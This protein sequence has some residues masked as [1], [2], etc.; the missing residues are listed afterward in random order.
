MV[1]GAGRGESVL[2]PTLFCGSV[3]EGIVRLFVRRSECCKEIKEVALD[4]SGS[5]CRSICFVQNDEGSKDEGQHKK[6]DAGET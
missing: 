4:L 1:G 6:K 5:G 2:C 3:E